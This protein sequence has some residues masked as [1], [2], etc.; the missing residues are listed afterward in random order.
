[1]KYSFLVLIGFTQVSCSDKE[2]KNQTNCPFEQS[3]S[4]S[5]AEKLEC[6]SG[7][8]GEN[9]CFW[10]LAFYDNSFEW[11]YSDIA[12]EGTYE[13]TDNQLIG[14][15]NVGNIYQGIYNPQTKQLTWE[16]ITYNMDE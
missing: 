7:S 14:Q 6:G 2:P 8:E 1:M 16:S 3:A 13:C 10:S 5:S 12:E 9:L 15:T 11:F 4:F